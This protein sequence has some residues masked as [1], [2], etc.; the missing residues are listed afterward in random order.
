[1]TCH[2]RCF[3]VVAVVFLTVMPPKKA[4]KRKAPL[5]KSGRKQ[6][7]ERCKLLCNSVTIKLYTIT[8]YAV[9]KQRKLE[10]G[11]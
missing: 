5:T 7:E 1:M 8:I 3:V 4:K 2:S 10:L 6:R 11:E 9:A